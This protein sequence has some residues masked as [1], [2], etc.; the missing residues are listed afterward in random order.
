[1]S[2]VA[3]CNLFEYYERVLPSNNEG[4]ALRSFLGC[5]ASALAYLHRTTIR[6]R[7]VKPTNI[8]VRDNKVYLADFG[9]SLDWEDLTGSTTNTY[10]VRTIRY[11]SPEVINFEPRNTSSD[12]W[13]LG[14]VFLEIYTVL[15]GRTM[16][17]LRQ[18]M[19]AH[20]RNIA[21]V[22]DWMRGLKAD[23]ATLDDEISVWVGNMLRINPQERTTALLLHDSIISSLFQGRPC[24]GIF[25]GECCMD[26]LPNSE[27]TDSRHGFSD[28]DSEEETRGTSTNAS[29]S[30]IVNKR[31]PISASRSSGRFPQPARRVSIPRAI[32]ASGSGSTTSFDRPKLQSPARSDKQLH[33]ERMTSNS[34]PLPLMTSKRGSI[35]KGQLPTLMARSWRDPKTLLTFIQYDTRFMKFLE[36]NNL[37]LYL[38][39]RNANVQDI[40]S[41]VGTLLESGIDPNDPKYIDSC[42]GEDGACP[43][44]WILHENW[45]CTGS[46][47]KLCQ[48]LLDYHANVTTYEMKNGRTALTRACSFGHLDVVEVLLNRGADV[49]LETE[50]A[51]PLQAAADFKQLEVVQY[52]VKHGAN[53]NLKTKRGFILQSIVRETTLEIIQCLVEHGA[54]VNASSPDTEPA[55]AVAAD[56]GL[57]DVVIYLV[58]NATDVISSAENYSWTPL[59]ISALN[60]HF[61]ILQY[62]LTVYYHLIM[63]DC[64]TDNGIASQK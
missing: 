34:S 58:E 8:L 26:F 17:D 2:P 6:H 40:E 11:C 55:L 1:M 18:H 48:R 53:V 38:L 45:R 61:D 31:P 10:T 23:Q 35:L 32:I 44:M 49:N 33:I 47:F 56:A 28:Q 25:S 54:D 43:H 13:S 3:E 50:H 27:A 36:H 4:T 57:L 37:E 16:D 46:Q 39:I 7:D 15:K 60:G 5:L 12:I 63:I 20:F 19:G 24:G 21:A 9:I 41:I 62:I 29:S 14:C 51:L 42:E 59:M 64:V 22:N 52:L 30:Q